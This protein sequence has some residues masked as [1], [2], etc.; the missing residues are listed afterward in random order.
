M[1]SLAKIWNYSRNIGAE[2]EADAIVISVL[3]FKKIRL[4]SLSNR[5]ATVYGAL[6]HVRTLDKVRN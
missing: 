3:S 6:S 5:P 4:V 2:G 1:M